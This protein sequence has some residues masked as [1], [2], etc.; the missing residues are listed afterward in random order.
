MKTNGFLLLIAW[1]VILL[2]A[3]T[4]LPAHAETPD[5]P[6]WVASAMKLGQTNKVQPYPIE[7]KFFGGRIIFATFTTPFLRVAI[8]AAEAHKKFKPFDASMITDEMLADTLVV[9]VLPIFSPDM[10]GAHRSAD[11]IVIKKTKSTDPTSVIQPLFVEPFSESAANGFGAHIERQGLIA[12]FPLT[13]LRE[14]SAFYLIYEDVPGAPT[15][16]PELPITKEM[17]QQGGIR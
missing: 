3:L 6:S 7:R 8:A 13:A 17:V 11:H 9:H 2:V 15:A 16:H 12:T 10:V 1:L 14:G 5:P 4:A